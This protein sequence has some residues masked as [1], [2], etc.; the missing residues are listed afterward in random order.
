MRFSNQVRDLR[1]RVYKGYK[2][3]FQIAFQSIMMLT[4]E[5]NYT[6]NYHLSETKPTQQKI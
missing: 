2:E 4:L 1:F 5:Q 6:A 3:A